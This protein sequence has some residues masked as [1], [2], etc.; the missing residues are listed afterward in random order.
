[1][2]KISLTFGEWEGA[3]AVADASMKANNGHLFIVT[4]KTRCQF[5]GRSPRARGRCRHWFQ[6]FLAHL[7]T[8]LLARS[9]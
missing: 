9:Q 3:K 8:A 4:L 5:C 2:S 1:M 7:D 6:T